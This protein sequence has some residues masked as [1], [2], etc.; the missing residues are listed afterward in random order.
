MSIAFATAIERLDAAPANMSATLASHMVAAAILLDS[1]T[2]LGTVFNAEFSLGLAKRLHLLRVIF[3]LLVTTHRIVSLSALLARDH[4][5][6]GAHMSAR[7][8]NAEDLR[9]VRGRA[10]AILAGTAVDVSL[11]CFLEDSLK[12]G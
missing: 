11:E 6:L 2:A 12:D 5:T 10:M 4:E 3:L 8:R 9:A 7:V 1:S